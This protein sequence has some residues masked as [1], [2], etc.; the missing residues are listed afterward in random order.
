MQIEDTLYV[1]SD[2]VTNGTDDILQEIIVSGTTDFGNVTYQCVDMEAYSKRLAT[3]NNN[4]Y[5]FKL[6]D[7]DDRLISLNGLNF[8]ATILVFKKEDIFDMI[9]TNIKLNLIDK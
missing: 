9:R 7:E 1:H 4:V 8:F 2:L 6:T 5:H 3:Q